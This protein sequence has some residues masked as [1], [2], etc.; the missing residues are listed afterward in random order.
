MTLDELVREYNINEGRDS[1]HNYSMYLTYAIRGLKEMNIDVSGAPTVTVLYPD[2]MGRAVLPPDMIK[3][4]RMGIKDG[5]GN[6]A[7]I[8][9]NEN[10][11]IGTDGSF[12]CTSPDSVIVSY[13][14]IAAPLTSPDI[15]SHFRNGEQIGRH[16]GNVG[17]SVYG[18]RIDYVKGQIQFTSNLNGGIL[19]EYLSA[20]KKVNGQYEIHPFLEEPIMA[21]I[22][23]SRIRFKNH[24]SRFEKREA[25]RDYINKKHHAGYRFVT[26]SAGSMINTSRKTFSLVSKW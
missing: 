23:Y 26:E 22:Y 14:T 13:P 16:Y 18:Y 12:A 17:G 24:I 21:W 15:T 2:D 4:M 20:P 10:I 1:L 7:E 9:R 8:Y 6:F 11:V 3:V 19:L 25:F 5:Q